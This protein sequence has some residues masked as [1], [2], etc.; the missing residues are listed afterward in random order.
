MVLIPKRNGKFRGIGLAK[1]LWKAFPRVINRRIGAAVQLHDTMHGFRTGRGAGIASLKN[2]LPHKL[3]KIRE[4][5]LYKVFLDLHKAY[6]ALNRESCMDILLVYGVGPRMKIILGH[7][8]DHLS[9][10]AR[11]GSYYGTPFKVNRGIT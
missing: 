2:K 3:T 8:W 6:D 9:M 1:V 5:V 10:V 4:E 7:Y 11:A